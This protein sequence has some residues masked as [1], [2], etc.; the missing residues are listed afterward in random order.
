V[1]DYYDLALVLR[2]H[3][4]VDEFV[5]DGLWVEVLFGLVN[6]ECPIIRLIEREIKEE[7]NDP[8]GSWR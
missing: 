7:Q 3:E 5:E 6:D 4:Q 8:T 1:G 2:I